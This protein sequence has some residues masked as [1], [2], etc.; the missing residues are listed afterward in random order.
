MVKGAPRI[1]QTTHVIAKAIDYSPKTNGK[2]L[3][4]K[5]MRTYLIE[6]GKVKQVPN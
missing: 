2:T 5:T 6:H 4:L 1:P 3:L